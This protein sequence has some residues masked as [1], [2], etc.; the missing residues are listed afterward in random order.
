[1]INIYIYINLINIENA[2]KL[3]YIINES[4]REAETSYLT[5]RIFLL[6]GT[7]GSPAGRRTGTVLERTDQVDAGHR[8]GGRVFWMVLFG[9]DQNQTPKLDW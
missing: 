6:K 9:V 8:L 5:L 4:P 1:M 3:Q 2:I 7:S